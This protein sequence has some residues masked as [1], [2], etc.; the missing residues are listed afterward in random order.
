[1]SMKKLHRSNRGVVLD[2][3]VLRSQQEFTIA[4][5]N[6]GQNARGDELGPR[7][8]IIRKREDIMREYYAANPTGPKV[9]QARNL[10]PDTFETPAQ[11]IERFKRE[12]EMR[13]M[14]AQPMVNPQTIQDAPRADNTPVRKARKL[15]EDE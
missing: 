9:A 1:M 2:L 14:D 12:K 3:D 5:G 7:G 8:K 10:M 11:A 6:A 13:E 4:L 15:S